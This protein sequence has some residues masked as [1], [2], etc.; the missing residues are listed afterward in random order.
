[1][2]LFNIDYFQLY[3]HYHNKVI[4]KAMQIKIFKFYKLDLLV[5]LIVIYIKTFQKSTIFFDF[6]KTDLI[7]YNPELVLQKI[8]SI[9]NQLPLY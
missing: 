2:Q 9:N 6:K 4:N 3:K 5:S 8:H 1:M 7:F